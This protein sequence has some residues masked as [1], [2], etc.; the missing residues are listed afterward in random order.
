[1]YDIYIDEEK[2]TGNIWFLV[3]KNTPVV[4][5]SLY[6]FR[7]E[8]EEY[9]EVKFSATNNFL[10]KL[11]KRWINY[12]F[13]IRDKNYIKFY[14]R[15]WDLKLNN[16]EEVISK[17]INDLKID[18]WTS[19][20]VAI[21][22]FETSHKNINIENLIRKNT[23]ICRCY[24]FNSKATDLLQMSDLLLG[25]SMKELSLLNDFNYEKIDIKLSENK[26]CTKWELKNYIGKYFY[27][28]SY[29]S[30]DKINL[31]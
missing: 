9:S 22:D 18:L 11:Y 15:K 28:K 16:K 14:R 31:E 23:R 8:I 25:C 7:Q 13:N 27:I 24:H 1:M 29:N 10:L 2:K 3:V 26:N 19:N 21:L 20:L 17:F 12:F 4:Q 6:N 5:Q 30:N